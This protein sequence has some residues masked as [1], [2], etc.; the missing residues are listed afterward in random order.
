[1]IKKISIPTYLLF[2]LILFFS[3]A[4]KQGEDSPLEELTTGGIKVKVVWN[5]PEQTAL[6]SK[7]NSYPPSFAAPAGVV[8]IQ[9]VITGDGMTT[10]TSNHNA[11]SG[12]GRTDNIPVGSNR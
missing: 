12:S 8:T 10:I 3:F 2:I 7:S 6:N 11:A 4:C 1:M 5:T 9:A